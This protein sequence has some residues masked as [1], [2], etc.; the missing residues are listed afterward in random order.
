LK[1]QGLKV[2]DCVSGTATEDVEYI[3]P[4][5]RRVSV[6]VSKAPGF[7]LELWQGEVALH[8][9]PLE[10]GLEVAARAELRVDERRM[11]E[12]R[13]FK[14][15][16]AACELVVLVDGAVA[17]LLVGATSWDEA[18][19]AGRFPT[20]DRAREVFQRPNLSITIV[21]EPLEVTRWRRDFHR[22]KVYQTRWRFRCDSSFRATMK[23]NYPETYARLAVEDQFF[24]GQPC[25][26]DPQP[27]RH[28]GL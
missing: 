10:G 9:M 25:G 2:T 11:R 5:G 28:P 24:V 15:N 19:P 6:A 4:S 20:L 21:P 8:E 13:E 3:Y 14:A 23:R 22:W 18:L 27:P 17:D 12:A 26:E 16:H 1:L 7:A